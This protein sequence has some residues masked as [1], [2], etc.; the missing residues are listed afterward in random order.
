MGLNS[1]AFLN[2]SRF[3]FSDKDIGQI[4][5]LPWM[6]K[7]ETGSFGPKG[8]EEGNHVAAT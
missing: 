6:I 2:A 7:F 4:R 8:I 3:S 5:N 1:M